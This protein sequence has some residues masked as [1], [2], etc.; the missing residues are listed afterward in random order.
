MKDV[1]KL[2]VAAVKCYIQK[3]EENLNR[4]NAVAQTDS[5]KEEIS[6]IENRLPRFKG[7]LHELQ[8]KNA[9]I[10]STGYIWNDD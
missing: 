1:R 6:K 4:Y 10:L 7:L 5:V 3:D 9:V 8:T 2:V